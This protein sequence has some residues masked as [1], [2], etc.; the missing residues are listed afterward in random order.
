MFPNDGTGMDDG[1]GVNEMCGAF[2][3]VAQDGS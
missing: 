1:I 2:Q 3:P